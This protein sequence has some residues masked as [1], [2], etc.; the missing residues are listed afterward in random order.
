MRAS[1]RAEIGGR[2]IGGEKLPV[3][4]LGFFIPA[5]LGQKLRPVPGGP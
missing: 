5:E 3:G 4:E 1:S 2:G